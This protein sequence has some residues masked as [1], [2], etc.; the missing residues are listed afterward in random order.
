M[1][2]LI[3]FSKYKTSN[4]T[5]LMS[6]TVTVFETATSFTDDGICFFNKRVFEAI[7][8]ISI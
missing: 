8:D 2:V 6:L 5:S 7:S 4:I 3:S 1:M